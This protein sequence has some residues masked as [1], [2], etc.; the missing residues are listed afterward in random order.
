[1]SA[2]HGEDGSWQPLLVVGLLLAALSFQ[3]NV[4]EGMTATEFAR[5]KTFALMGCGCAAVLVGAIYWAF[6]SKQAKEYRERQKRRTEVPPALLSPSNDNVYLGE[7]LD[8]ETS[9]FLPDSIRSRHVHILGATGSGK[10]ESVVLNFIGQ[11]IDRGFP[12]VVLDAKGDHSFLKFLE[13]RAKGRLKMFDLSSERSP[14]AYDP[15]AAGTPSEAAQRLFNSL[16]WSEPYYRSKA[17]TILFRSFDALMKLGKRPT[18]SDLANLLTSANS[19]NAVVTPGDGSRSKVTERDF[20]ELAGLRD[21]I[22]M[23]GNG[24][25]AQI[26]TTR[27]EED[28]IRI[29]KDLQQGKILYFRLQALLDADSAAL[30]GRLVIND[31]AYYSGQRHLAAQQPAFT[32]VYLDEFGSLVCPAFLELIAKA[33]SAGLALHFSH[34]SAYDLE[35]ESASFLGRVMDNASTKIVLRTYDHGSTDRMAKSFGLK[36]TVKMTEQAEGEVDD[37]EKTGMAS[38]RE[39]ETFRASPTQ[40]KSLPTGHGFAFVAHGEDRKDGGS[41]VFRLRF[42][43]L[44]SHQLQ[45]FAHPQENETK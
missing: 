35:E 29:D 28:T 27:G 1:M 8:L 43:R 2:D 38:V 10:T 26:L 33:R 20:E 3:K 44:K 12:V 7:D 6:F 18:F 34:Q 9:I 22:S 39:V 25:F 30:V 31:L 42:P 23:L 37:L 45:H 24:H 11:D 13:D 5:V 17:R 40:M 32:P 16:I 4:V 36:T 19:L 41:S 21:Q 15:L 14:C